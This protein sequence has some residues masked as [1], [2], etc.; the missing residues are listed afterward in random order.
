MTRRGP[1]TRR[2]NPEQLLNRIL[3]SKDRDEAVRV[4]RDRLG[5]TWESG[6][7]A[8]FRDGV[9]DATRDEPPPRTPNPY[10]AAPART[11][12]PGGAR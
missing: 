6:H 1:V 11:D 10:R 9:R 4:L 7:S 8:G 12:A 3:G 2:A 5:D